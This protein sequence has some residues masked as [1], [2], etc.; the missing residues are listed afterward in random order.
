M[1]LGLEK[2]KA[3]VCAASQGLGRAIAMSLAQEGAELF[4]CA[5]KEEELVKVSEEIGVLTG[6]KVHY[7]ACDLK[8]EESRNALVAN[9]VANLGAPDIVIH[10]VGGPPATAAE[11]TPLEQWQDGFDQLFKSTA[12]LNLAF[13]PHMKKQNWGRI[14]VVTSLSVIEPIAN[15]AIS[16]AIRSAVTAMSK[17]LS[18][19]VASHNITVNCVAPGMIQTDRTD[20]LLNARAEK[21][22]K[23]KA[24]FMSDYVESIPA[25]RLGKPE[26]FA[27]VVTFLVSQPA[28]YITGQTIVVDGG[29]RRS[30]N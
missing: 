24:D 22:G 14:I 16:N 28:S 2:K 27:S 17:T 8:S 23:S 7:A 29:K 25:R 6:A 13:V 12:H 5:R 11:E 20:H 1:K 18:D 9:V 26:E 4:I 15:L 3:L 30:V 10:N 19:E 21:T